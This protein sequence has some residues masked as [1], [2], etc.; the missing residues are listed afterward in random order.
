MKRRT[1]FEHY[2]RTGR[3]LAEPVEIK[4]NPWHD[5]DDGRFTFAGRGRNYG[6]GQA[7]SAAAGSRNAGSAARDATPAAR[8]VVAQRQPKRSPPAESARPPVMRTMGLPVDDGVRPSNS[9]PATPAQS[10]PRPNAPKPKIRPLRVRATA[11]VLKAIPGYPETGG[12]SWRAGNDKVFVEAANR[13]NSQRGLKAGD[14]RYVDAQFLKA[15]AMVESGGNKSAF[16][17]DPLQANNPGD[18]KSPKPQ[19]TGLAKDQLMTPAISAEAALKWLEFRGYYRDIQ[20]RR[21][22]WLGFETALRRYNARKDS[23]PSGVPHSVWYAREVLKLYEGAKNS[24]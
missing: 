6:G 16:L 14:P 24:R 3:R 2:V 22:P 10:Q 19:V 12:S 17:T 1:A 13:F 21:G 4:F 20:R 8:R 11:T 15:W 23:H 9:K 7:H 18:F 5:P